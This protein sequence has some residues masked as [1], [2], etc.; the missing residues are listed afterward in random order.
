MFIR[1]KIFIIICYHST[2]KVLNVEMYK[3]AKC[4]NVQFIQKE[5]I[6][7]RYEFKFSIFIRPARGT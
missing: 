5:S 7:K 1:L 2:V 3:S 4:R 6:I